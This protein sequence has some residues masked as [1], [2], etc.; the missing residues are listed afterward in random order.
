MRSR[1]PGVP[2]SPSTNSSVASGWEKV[3][4]FGRRNS[5]T[6]TAGPVGAAIRDSLTPL[7]MKLVYRNGDPARWIL[8]HRL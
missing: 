1:W 8:E 2:A 6:K 4:A 5:R 7:I 3:V